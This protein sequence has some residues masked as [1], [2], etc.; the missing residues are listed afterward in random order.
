M[1]LAKSHDELEALWRQS[2][3]S[4]GAAALDQRPVPLEGLPPE[5]VLSSVRL[6]LS[7]NLIDNLDWLSA[8]AAAVGLYELAAAIPVGPERHQL[9]RRVAMHLR[10][11]NAATFVA[12]ATAL[13]IS[14]RRGLAG[15]DIQARVA[16]SLDLPLGSPAHVD[17]LALALISRPQ[18]E[19]QWLSL[20]STGS[21]PSRRLAARLLERAARQAALRASQGDATGLHIFETP[22][23][24]AAWNRLLQDRES[25]V[26]AHVATARGLLCEHI[27]SFDHEIDRE[28]R[29]SGTI[30]EWR[31]AATSLTA[32]MAL[33]PEAVLERCQRILEDSFNE[34]DPGIA[35]AM[36]LGIPRAA[37]VEPEAASELL[38]RLA[39]HASVSV[40]ETFVE[41][42]QQ[43]LEVGNEAF[44]A[45]R[46]RLSRIAQQT[47]QGD[48]GQEALYTCLIQELSPD[49]AS[50]SE[51]ILRR[52]MTGLE[53]FIDQGAKAAAIQAE[54]TLEQVQ[55]AC[56]KLS[57]I[58]I[59]TH[60][61]LLSAFQLIR[62]I[63]AGLLKRPTLRNLL[64][65]DT[66]DA[67]PASLGSLE[68]ALVQASH[69]LVHPAHPI[70]TENSPTTSL[71]WHQHRLR[72]LLHLVDAD[73]TTSESTPRTSDTK[74]S[75]VSTT[76][77]LL[78]Q[79]TK[80]PDTSLHRLLFAA[81]ARAFDALIRDE[82]C[83]VSDALLVWMGFNLSHS[84]L[85]IV[86]EASMLTE[87]ETP[88]RR[89][90]ALTR[91][92]TMA[93]A[94][95]SGSIGHSL[96][97]L[98]DFTS[99]LVAG[100]PRLE[101]LR[102]VLL[103][104][105]TSLEALI[106]ARSLTELT[107][108]NGAQPF[109][110]LS[111]AAQTLALLLSGARRRLSMDDTANALEISQRVNAVEVAVQ[112]ALRNDRNQLQ[113]AVMSAADALQ[114]TLPTSI[115]DLCATVLIRLLSRPNKSAP[116]DH[117]HSVPKPAKTPSLPP[118]LPPGR[119]LGGFYVLRKLG[120]GGVASV[121]VA[122]RSEERHQPDA[123]LFALKTPEYSGNVARTLSESE[124][125]KMFREEA[126]ALLALPE[127]PNL[128]KFVTFD[129]GV[130][131]KPIL[132]MELIEGVSLE[133][134]ITLRD[135]T[136]RTVFNILDGIAAG[137]TAMHDVRIAHLD[138][139]PS[140]IILRSATSNELDLHGPVPVLVDFGLAGTRM[141]PGCATTAYGAP[142]I[143]SLNPNDPSP[144]PMPA[145]IY[146]FG[147][148]A[149]ELLTGKPLFQA[150]SEIAT[151]TLHIA[152][153]GVPP[154]LE[155]L[156]ATPEL[157]PLVHTLSTALRRSPQERASIQELRSQLATNA[158]S[159]EQQS[160]PLR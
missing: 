106:A 157:E 59:Q 29:A 4:L 65:L 37:E 72:T 32:S 64:R 50:P 48:I 41:L 78:A 128:S 25:L 34:R 77:E 76:R 141:R 35:N 17:A 115:A 120:S 28:L 57:N 102:H 145:D 68:H 6:A 67:H 5:A 107:A 159:L 80:S 94:S 160:W 135:L 73:W 45:M 31:R 52:T 36:V 88:I 110:T 19:T 24:K 103:Q 124:F 3:A 148:L 15:P 33:R 62:N 131:P 154:E 83:E 129:A 85:E 146:A 140:N 96:D 61:D 53:C 95:S 93:H 1:H 21:L 58:R 10:D 86:A 22:S 151:I 114:A 147:C 150:N 101:A 132:V 105:T 18:L 79:C 40:A 98:S 91:S 66:R 104:L 122:K 119:T 71:T 11:G 153:D 47:A 138:L 9:G 109:H 118:W 89:Y 112:Q 82:L 84:D 108:P 51:A 20:P 100:S 23:V 136:M 121:F 44:E 92:F 30:G 113:P 158:V 70:Q 54:R 7:H 149:F 14:S 117:I 116:E 27:S 142:E 111:Q 156:A 87:L 69:W 130:K 38:L 125:S 126:G 39:Q 8:P 139:K 133:R 63:D 134:A 43:G 81:S 12:L 60:Q 90:A 143:W 16:L 144:P 123:K 13:A 74:A 56:H 26:W 127:H 2:I 152:H 42:R 99:S 155:A 46:L 137:L 49:S 55:S 97:N 75:R